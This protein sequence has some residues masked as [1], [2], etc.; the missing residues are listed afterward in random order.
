ME[1]RIIVSFVVGWD[2][3]VYLINRKRK[4]KK[5]KTREREVLGIKYDL[6]RRRRGGGGL[7][8]GIKINI[9]NK[10]PGIGLREG[11]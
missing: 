8:Y 7:K 1:K 6:I 11:G 10:P 2:R 4:Q 9:N 3:G 5:K